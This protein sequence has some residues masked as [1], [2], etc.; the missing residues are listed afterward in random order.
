MNGNK[1]IDLINIISNGDA[2]DFTDTINEQ[3]IQV[4]YSTA[5]TKPSPNM[6]PTTED[7]DMLNEI[8]NEIVELNNSNPGEVSKPKLSRMDSMSMLLGDY[9]LKE[10]DEFESNIQM[11]DPMLGNDILSKTLNIF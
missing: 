2:S 10:F 3:E 6:D 9:S 11:N 7:M 4:S 1:D 5:E 8:M